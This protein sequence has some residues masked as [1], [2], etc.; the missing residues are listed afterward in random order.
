[1]TG[2]NTTGDANVGGQYTLES[3]AAVI[4]G[5]SEF[6]GGVVSPVGA[7]VG[8]FIML[9]TGSLLSFVDISTVWQLS[10]QGGILIVVLGLRALSRQGTR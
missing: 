9:L 2:L 1:M 10:A 7:V 5:G 6:S 3:I 4:V 8:A